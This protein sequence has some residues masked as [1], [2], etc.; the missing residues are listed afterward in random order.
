[1][2]V[3]NAPSMRGW[4]M[5]SVRLL[6]SFDPYQLG[7]RIEIFHDNPQFPKHE[8]YKEEMFKN[9]KR[10]ISISSQLYPSY[11]AKI[12]WQCTTS[13]MKLIRA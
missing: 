11:V 5:S 9:H 6:C 7:S 3:H 13:N 12:L 2:T 10:Y 1:M 4:N 8:D